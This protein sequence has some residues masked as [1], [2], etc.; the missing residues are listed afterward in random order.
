[1]SDGGL[2]IQCT[3][4]FYLKM[5]HVTIFHNVLELILWVYEAKVSLDLLKYS[6]QLQLPQELSL[7][8]GMWTGSKLF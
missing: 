7:G 6:K 1:M 3:C 2:L 4:V 8:T 5:V